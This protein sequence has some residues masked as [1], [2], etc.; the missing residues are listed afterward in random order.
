M[1]HKLQLIKTWMNYKNTGLK[2]HLSQNKLFAKLHFISNHNN[3]RIKM[4][5]FRITSIINITE[6]I[7]KGI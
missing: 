5:R 1:Q 2:W 7:P 4:S 6:T 3:K